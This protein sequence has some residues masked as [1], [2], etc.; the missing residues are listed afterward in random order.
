AELEAD[1]TR[2]DDTQF[3]GNTGQSQ[4]T[5]VGKDFFLV[6]RQTGKF[7][8]RRPGGD[9]DV[10]GDQ[11]FV[12]LTGNL[13]GPATVNLGAERTLAMEERNLV[14]LDVGTRAT[15][16]CDEALSRASRRGGVVG[17]VFAGAS[18]MFGSVQLRFGPGAALV[19][20]RAS[21]TWFAAAGRPG[22]AAAL[23][24]AKLPVGNG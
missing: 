16:V 4:R 1:Y 2:T 6:K 12:G 13:D 11:I 3:F 19:A 24:H 5:V 20:A 9:D 10:F 14:L 17:S 7:A 15:S 18:V 22:V 23:L 21:R 8:R